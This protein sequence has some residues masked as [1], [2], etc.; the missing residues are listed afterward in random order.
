[1]SVRSNK[2][3]PPSNS[4]G[5]HIQSPPHICENLGPGPVGNELIAIYTKKETIVTHGLVNAG[6]R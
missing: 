6:R 3:V 1:V 4:Y 5:K 2:V